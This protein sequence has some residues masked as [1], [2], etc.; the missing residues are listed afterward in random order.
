MAREDWGTFKYEEVE[1]LMLK[2]RLR[3]LRVGAG[4][5]ATSMGMLIGVI[6]VLVVKFGQMWSGLL[7][8]PALFCLMGWVHCA[9][10]IKNDA[11]PAVKSLTDAQRL[12]YLI[13]KRQ[14]WRN[15]T[16]STATPDWGV[17]DRWVKGRHEYALTK[18]SQY[19]GEI[20]DSDWEDPLKWNPVH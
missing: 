13:L 4:V 2:R 7:V 20:P 16:E 5:F 6:V 3:R 11:A 18:P 19:P 8:I 15:E 17:D 9:L 10:T 12:Y 14:D 1:L